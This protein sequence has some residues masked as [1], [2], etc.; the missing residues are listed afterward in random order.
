MNT[1]TKLTKGYIQVY[2]G[3]GKGKTTAALGL[4]LRAVGRNMKVVIIQ[5]MKG[6]K[7]G[8]I[9]AAKKLFPN[10][11]IKQFGMD[12]FVHIDKPTSEDI[13]MAKKA[14]KEATELMKNGEYDIIIL[15]EINVALFYKLVTIEEVLHLISLKPSNAELILTGRY[16]PQSL[17]ETADVVTE[18]REV[19]HYFSKGIEARDGIER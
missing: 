14:L 2:T 1:E 3:N 19:K 6:Q 15:D 9:E 7:Y 12:T 13:A 11:I 16:A 5:F 17:L 8:E 4:A 10:L 18:M